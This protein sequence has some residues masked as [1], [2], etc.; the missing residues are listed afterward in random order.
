M[1]TLDSEE[2]RKAS[3][4]DDKKLSRILYFNEMMKD[5]HRQ[6]TPSDRVFI[7][8]TLSLSYTEKIVLGAY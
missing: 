3:V 2:P 8:D 4:T 6:T 1:G 7:P 5:Y